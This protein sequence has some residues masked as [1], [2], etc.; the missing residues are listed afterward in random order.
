MALTLTFEGPN[1]GQLI[2]AGVTKCNL[3]CFACG[4]TGPY[5]WK[6]SAGGINVSADNTG[7]ATIVPTTT[8]NPAGAAYGIGAKF[9]GSAGVTDC[10]CIFWGCDGTFQQCT[11][12]GCG[13]CMGSSC[14]NGCHAGAPVVCVA[15]IGYHP[16]KEI[17]TCAGSVVSDTCTCVGLAGS[18]FCDLR[19]AGMISSGCTPCAIVMNNAIVTV[20]DSTGASVS[21][22]LVTS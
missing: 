12:V 20:T 8:S 3:K 15:V 13:T 4:G 22:T 14:V 17:D 11:T 21:R 7:I 5:T 19:T 2:Y 16:C 6:I 1:T 9:C 18:V 10:Q